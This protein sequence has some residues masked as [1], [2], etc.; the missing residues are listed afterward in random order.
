MMTDIT[1]K[2]YR[3]PAKTGNKFQ[4]GQSG[5]PKGRPQGSRNKATLAALALLGNDLEAVTEKLVG[6]AKAGEAWAIKLVLDKLVPNAKD[7]PVSFRLPRLEKAAE[8]REALASILRAVSQGKITPDEGQAVA[9]LLNGL[10]L[11]LIVEE[12]EAQLEHLQGER[13]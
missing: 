3:D 11:A 5:N 9:A 7:A 13:R 12:L 1:R 4:P 6:K 8:L 2:A 10:G